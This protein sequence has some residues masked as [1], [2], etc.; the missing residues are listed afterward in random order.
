MI[1]LSRIS[2][3]L[4][5]QCDLLLVRA[6]ILAD[7]GRAGHEQH[8]P[9]PPP[10]LAPRPAQPAH[11]A[12]PADHRGE[13]I[14]LRGILRSPSGTADSGPGGNRGHCTGDRLDDVDGLLEALERGRAPLGGPDLALPH[15]SEAATVR[16]T[17]TCPAAAFEHSRA[18]MFNV[19]RGTRPRPAPPHR[20]RCRSPPGAGTPGRPR[21]P[22]RT[23]PGT[24][25]RPG[26][27]AQG[28]RTPRAPRRPQLDNP[29]PPGLHGV[30]GQAGEPR[31][32][33]RGGGIPA[34]PRKPRVPANVSDQEGQDRAWPA[35][36]VRYQLSQ[37]PPPRS[38][39]QVWAIPSAP[40]RCRPSPPISDAAP[41]R[42]R[43]RSPPAHRPGRA[44]G[45]PAGPAR[46][47]RRSPD[48]APNQAAEPTA[49]WATRTAG[50]RV[51]IKSSPRRWRSPPRPGSSGQARM[52]MHSQR[53]AGSPGHAA[54]SLS[55]GG[56]HD[57]GR[58]PRA[59][60]SARRR[61]SGSR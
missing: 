40:A 60:A 10:D 49:A 52:F 47:A 25:R 46:R 50:R 5:S 4:R 19:A 8:P 15:S 35:G 30:P 53:C 18:A 34:L 28:T 51:V 32:K 56:R 21:S 24:P 33:D 45:S 39:G 13:R 11:L 59:R 38:C 3:D 58:R 42:S 17:R 48:S 55:G 57:R 16:V 27:P 36:A 44:D 2:A 54:M 1:W 61:A 9:S 41:R 7:L 37:A 26:P 14:K 20:R 43:T 22:R 12:L 23:W 6:R 31:G 29:A